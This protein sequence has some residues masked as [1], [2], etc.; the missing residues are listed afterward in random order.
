MTYLSDRQRVEMALPAVLLHQCVGS[1]I[2]SAEEKG[3]A[4]SAEEDRLFDREIMHL[5]TEACAAPLEGLDPRRAAKLAMRIKRTRDLVME[6]YRDDTMMKVFLAV[7][8]VVKL[9]TDDDAFLLIEGSDFERAITMLLPELEK[10]DDLWD[11]VE[12]SGR[13]QARKILLRLQAAGLYQGV[14]DAQDAA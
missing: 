1:C 4:P 5:L 13:K 2:A 11:A 7:L 6:P 10:H 14:A 9:L 12:R 3:L 8:H